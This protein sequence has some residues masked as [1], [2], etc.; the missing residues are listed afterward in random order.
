MTRRELDLAADLDAQL[1]RLPAQ[2]AVFVLHADSGS[3]YLART[4]NLRRRL[5]R[6]LA[7]REATGRFL[8]LRG[9]ARRAEIYLTASR[10]QSALLFYELA[11]HHFPDDYAAR[12]RLR[13][14][15]YVKLILSNEF[16]R[17]QVTTR[18]SGSGVLVGPFRSRAT[19]ERF[20]QD[21]LDLFQV[22][23][24]QDDLLPSPEHPGCV[25][26]EMG[27]CLRPCQQVVSVAEYAAEC[28][29][30]RAFLATTGAE[31]LETV[32]RSRDRLIEAMEFEA[33]QR[34]H[35]RYQRIEQVIRSRDALA[36]DID[37]L[38]GVAVSRLP[39]DGVLELRFL[40]SGVWLPAV[41]FRVSPS[42]SDMAPL[43]RRLK[44]V[45]STLSP[46]RAG[47]RER[48]E[49]LALLAR[50]FYSSWRDGEWIEF[51][52]LENLPYRKLVRALSRAA[53]GLSAAP[54]SSP[55]LPEPP[56][57]PVESH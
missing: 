32:G 29:R 13:F 56:S 44:E 39:E 3:P 35:Q 20:E 5:K 27:R 54:G 6:L 19:A 43:D 41:E 50:W 23:R 26:G 31:T 52:S 21:V 16:P 47:V 46:P 53:S 22:R 37:A 12:I 2:P 18:L 49:H 42:G 9:V 30:L 17:T 24:C 25:Y 4:S 57:S 51:D 55:L 40:L 10:L 48:Q 45:V 36:R 28:E 8:Y 7:A 15:A 33:A 11:R 38:H 1:E 14:P 34:Q